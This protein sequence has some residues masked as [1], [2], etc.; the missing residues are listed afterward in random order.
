MEVASIFK[1]LG[2]EAAV[3]LDGG[4]STQ[5]MVRNPQTDKIEMRN[6]PSDPT[7]GFGGRERARLNY[8]IVTKE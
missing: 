1:A 7:N 8:W 4:G 6:W 2:C 3:N 5:M